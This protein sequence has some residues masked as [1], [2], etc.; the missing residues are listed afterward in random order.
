MFW[1]CGLE[2]TPEQVFELP[3]AD[4]EAWDSRLE[5]G[6]PGHRVEIH[7]AYLREFS[8]AQEVRASGGVEVAFR[9]GEIVSTL[10]AERLTLEHQRDRFGLSGGVVLRAGDSLEVQA[11]TLVWAGEDQQLRIPGTL[12]VMVGRG[13]ERGRNLISN[14]SVDTWSLESVTGHWRVGNGAEV[15]VRAEREQSRRIEGVQEVTYTGVDVH[16]DGLRL[17]GAQARFRPAVHRLDF[18]GGV[19]GADSLAQFSADRV[20]VDMWEERWVARGAVRYREEEAEL[21]ADEVGEDRSSALIQARGAPAT[22][23][24]EQRQ[25]EARE[26]SYARYERVLRARDTVVLRERDRQLRTAELSYERDTGFVRA[27]GAVVLQAP[28][29]EGLLSGDSLFFD[30]EQE[31]GWIEGSSSLRRSVDE[32][33]ELILE[34]TGLHFDLVRSVLIGTG[35]FRVRA[36]GVAVQAERGVYEADSSRVLVAGGVILNQRG[37]AQNY[38]TQMEADSM[39]ISLSHNRVEQVAIIGRVLGQIEAS[40]RQSWVAGRKGRILLV[41]GNLDQVE[42][43]AEADVTYRDST[44]E[45]VSRFRGAQVEL[46]F[47]S[48]GLRQALV[49]GSAELVSRLQEDDGEVSDNEVSGEELTIFFVDGAIAEVRI[50]PDIEGNYYPPEEEP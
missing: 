37:S 34:T 17:T 25:V 49:S 1:A 21:R 20:E 5:I 32:G 6:R 48:E 28:E 29:L 36:E 15:E 23:V 41:D 43:D 11:D 18:G 3:A 40:G 12:R 38:H 16:Y 24:Q 47:D 46:H 50:G 19:S 4:G 45:E 2:Q 42:I 9:D 14:F 30:L 27:R 7:A 39:V 44:E 31:V 13:W 22:F 33:D 26:L 35:G 10:K 8:D